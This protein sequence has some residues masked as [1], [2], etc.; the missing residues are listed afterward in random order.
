MQRRIGT[1]VSLERFLKFVG[2]LSHSDYFG[3]ADGMS[4]NR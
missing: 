2:I 3:D 1:P 4:D